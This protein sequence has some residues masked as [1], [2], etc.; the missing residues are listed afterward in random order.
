MF[1][2]KREEAQETM[3]VQKHNLSFGQNFGQT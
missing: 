1:T 3:N 2:V